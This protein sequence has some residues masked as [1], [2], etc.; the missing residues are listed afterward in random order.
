MTG[1]D[2]PFLHAVLGKKQFFI[3]GA[4][5]AGQTGLGRVCCIWLASATTTSEKVWLFI[6]IGNFHKGLS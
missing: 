5:G 1:T 6:F 3:V 4:D 2:P